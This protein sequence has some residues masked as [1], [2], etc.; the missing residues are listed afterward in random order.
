M[1]IFLLPHKKKIHKLPMRTRLLKEKKSQVCSFA[2]WDMRLLE[3]SIFHPHERLNIHSH[4]RKIAHNK[5]YTLLKMTKSWS[6][7][8][9]TCFKLVIHWMKHPFFLGQKW[10]IL[11]ISTSYSW[12]AQ[13]LMDYI[14]ASMHKPMSR[15]QFCWSPGFS[16]KLSQLSLDWGLNTGSM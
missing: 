10:S 12:F 1:T 15:S 16:R 7:S 2:P 6:S 4:T 5:R 3:Q 14:E 8:Q 9:L 13:S 11:G